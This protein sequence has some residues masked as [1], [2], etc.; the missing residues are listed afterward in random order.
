MDLSRRT[1]NLSLPEWARNEGF[2]GPKRL[3]DTLLCDRCLSDSWGPSG[4]GTT[5]AEDAQGTPT[6]SHKSPSILFFEDK[7]E[8]DIN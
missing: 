8:L 5:R 6:Q 3:A 1:V 4:R 7:T 2:T